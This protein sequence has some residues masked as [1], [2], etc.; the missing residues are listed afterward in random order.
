[1]KKFRTGRWIPALLLIVVLVTAGCG[2]KGAQEVKLDPKNPTAITIWHYYNGAQQ[3]A[4]D[5]AVAEFN[6]TVG[7]EKGIVVEAYSQSSI[8]ELTQKV[9]A[10]ANKEVGADEL[11]DVFAAYADTAYTLDQMGLA[12]SLDPY[13]SEEDLAAYVDGYIE[14]GRI[15]SEEQL[16]IFPIAKSTEVLMLNKTDWDKFAQATGATNADLET[17][18]GVTRTAEAYYQWTDSLTP[19][20]DDGKAFFGRDAL[21]N[22]MIIGNRQLGNEIFEVHNGQ[23]EINIDKAVYKR[24]WENYYVPMVKGHFAAHGRFRADDANA[25]DIIALVGSTTG[26]TYFPQQVVL[27]DNESYP[28]EAVT[29]PAP[30]FQDGERYAVQQGAGMMVVKST[31]EKEYAATIFLKWFTDDGRN[32]DFSLQSG[33]LPVKKSANDWTKIQSAL[34]QKD[35]AASEMF[36]ETM[37]TAI[38]TVT[39]SKMYTNKPFDEGTWAR[40]ILENNMAEQ[41]TRDRALIEAQMAEGF[42]RTEATE[43]FVSEAHF[44]ACFEEFS[45]ALTNPPAAE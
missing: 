43:P 8:N 5:Q 12:A 33:Y 21:A 30:I 45:Q 23:A 3:L 35:G 29:L 10:A 17:I 14:E 37:H 7:Y 15:D 6:D 44:E 20:A 27:N 4:F 34:E 13:L 25:G 22:Y 9:I 11:P 2:S 42:T 38:D 32:I 19:E 18:E 1:M 40:S 28:I 24:L 26:A 16:K 41:I 31:P 39:K 36:E